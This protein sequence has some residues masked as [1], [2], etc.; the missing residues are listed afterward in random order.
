MTRINEELLKQ[1][2]GRRWQP[3]HEIICRKEEFIM[4][5]KAVWKKDAVSPEIQELLEQEAE[6]LDAVLRNLKMEDIHIS[7]QLAGELIAHDGDNVWRG[8]EFYK[9]LLDEAI[10]YEKDG[11]CNAIP[12]DR[13]IAVL[14][15]G[16]FYGVQNGQQAG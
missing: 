16:R 1:R 5:K 14:R 15:L 6:I 11:T 13:L 2:E 7:Y 3:I 8:K 9:F 4:E 10:V 12:D